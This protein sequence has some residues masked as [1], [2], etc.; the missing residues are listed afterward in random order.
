MVFVTKE[1]LEIPRKASEIRTRVDSKI[2][3]VSS[4]EEGNRAARFRDGLLK[5]SIGSDSIDLAS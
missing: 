1:E 4:T 2:E 5:K 3:E